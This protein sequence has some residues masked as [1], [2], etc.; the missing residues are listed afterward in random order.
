MN[1]PETVFAAALNAV[2]KLPD[3]FVMR[4]GIFPAESASRKLFHRFA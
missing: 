2:S 4:A 3:V 1:E